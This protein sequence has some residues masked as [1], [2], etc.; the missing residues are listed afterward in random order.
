MTARSRRYSF[1]GRDH[2]THVRFTGDEYAELAATAT[3]AG[4]TTT[5]YV[6]EAA[7]AAVRGVN[8]TGEVDTGTRAELAALQRD[9]FAAR[10][11]VNQAAAELRGTPA[12][13]GAD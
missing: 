8:A 13:S 9:L 1:P 5:G 2:R 11:A 7:L 4:L 3:R 10:A 6:W 12:G